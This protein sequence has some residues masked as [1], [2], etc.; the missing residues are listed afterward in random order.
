MIGEIFRKRTG[1]RHIKPYTGSSR[2]A[3]HLLFWGVF[4]LFLVG[5]FYCVS[6]STQEGPLEIKKHLYLFCGIQLLLTVYIH[7][8]AIYLI[9]RLR[10][11][12]IPYAIGAYFINF[13]L[14]DYLF[15][16]PDM[17]TYLH[18]KENLYFSANM[19]SVKNLFFFMNVSIYINLLSITLKLLI[20]YYFASQKTL[21]LTELQNQVEVDFLKAQIKPHFLFNALN[22]IY[23]MALNDREAIALILDLSKLLRYLLYE[24]R[25]QTSLYEEI[26]I[27]QIFVQMHPDTHITFHYGNFSNTTIR[28]HDLF[29]SIQN[30]YAAPVAAAYE[31]VREDHTFHFK[32]TGI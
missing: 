15:H 27:I 30:I 11:L 8:G 22:S 29:A 13:L 5:Y 3:L 31:L 19:F 16:L 32:P 28:K 17:Q 14:L 24:D 25:A 1:Y 6:M 21:L 12:I 23:G 20:D 18:S 9:R 26:E 2:V 10:L 7:Y 4:Y